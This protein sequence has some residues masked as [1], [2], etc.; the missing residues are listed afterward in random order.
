LH[1]RLRLP[2]F[3]LNSLGLQQK[4]LDP[5]LRRD[6]SFEDNYTMNVIPAQA[7]IQCL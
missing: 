3:Y 4:T 2:I 7:G 6:D 1:W 5:G